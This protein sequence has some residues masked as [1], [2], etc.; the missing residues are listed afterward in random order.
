L[1][2]SWPRRWRDGFSLIE[3]LVALIIASMALAGVLELQRQLGDG[4]MRYQRV[5]TLARLERDAMALTADLNPT[6]QPDGVRSLAGGDSLRW[7]AEPLGPPALNTG[8]RQAGR[9]FELRL[10]QLT[11]TLTDQ[12]AQPLGQFAFDRVGWRR[13]VAPAPYVPPPPAPARPRQPAGS[14]G[15]Q[16][17][18]EPV[19]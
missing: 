4:Q 1:A 10:Y 8:S 14:P 19:L 3:A 2:L 12:G 16:P 13:L 9:A 7:H 15:G 18:S 11:V 17:P 6:D 5:L